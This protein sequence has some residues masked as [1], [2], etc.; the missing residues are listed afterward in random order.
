MKLVMRMLAPLLCSSAVLAAP[1]PGQGHVVD[2]R[3][4]TVTAVQDGNVSYAWSEGNASGSGTLPADWLGPPCNA[5]AARPGANTQAP[6][7]NTQRPAANIQ[8]SAGTAAQRAPTGAAAQDA[9]AQEILQAHN[10]LR[11]LHGAPPLQWSNEIAAYAQRW[12]EQIDELK[13]SDSYDSPLGR[14]G[15]NL[16]GGRT[17][18]AA[19]AQAWYDESRGYDYQRVDQGARMTG[20]FTTMIWKGVRFLGCARVG[21][22]VS[23]NYSAGAGAADCADPNFNMD[24]CTLQQV[25]PVSRS[26]QAC[27]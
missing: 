25:L 27:R 17:S 9:F 1:A 13:H 26:E 3:C 20:H 5:A 6:A 21:S 11:C 8:H 10:R 7:T 15:E 23:C 19:A 24:R 4:V 2:G 18:G 16:S 22:N 12:L 14:M